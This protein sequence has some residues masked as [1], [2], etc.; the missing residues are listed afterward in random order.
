MLLECR[1][2]PSQPLLYAYCTALRSTCSQIYDAVMEGQVCD[3]E[4]IMLHT[5]GIHLDPPG[6]SQ[7]VE[8]SHNA[9][10]EALN[11][12]DKGSPPAITSRLLFRKHI[13][14]AFQHI[15]HCTRSSLLHA[16]DECNHALVQLGIIVGSTSRGD[17]VPSFFPEINRKS[18]GLAPP[19]PVHVVSLQE[20]TEHWKEMLLEIVDACRWL[21]AATCW[22]ELRESLIV[23]AAKRKN[24]PIV[25]SIVHRALAMPT[26]P[27]YHLDEVYQV[28]ETTIES[29][30][31]WSSDPCFPSPH[32]ASLSPPPLLI[33]KVAPWAPT[34]YMTSAE[35]G[36]HCRPYIDATA[37]NTFTSTTTTKIMVTQTISDAE[38]PGSDLTKMFL[39]QCTI[40]IQAWCHT[41]CLNRC[42]QRRR[43]RRLVEDWQNMIDHG[44]NAESSKEL[45]KWCIEVC[46]WDWHEMEADIPRNDEVIMTPVCDSLHF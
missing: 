17:D 44:Y 30:S 25:R 7:H 23:F 24:Q 13:V 46:G 11:G 8:S 37:K 2:L 36:L 34:E 22:K 1:L 45:Q 39:Q 5:F 14:S 38:L 21:T 19:R 40:V 33:S 35:F 10:D 41:M 20:T 28:N 42:R 3:D 43:L 16:T 18:M 12:I 15:K 6:S 9:L 32:Q 29:S 26:K 4:D 31:S 27:A